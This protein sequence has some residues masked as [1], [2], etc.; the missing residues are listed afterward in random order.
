[1]HCLHPGSM[2]CSQVSFLG[3]LGLKTLWWPCMHPKCTPLKQRSFTFMLPN[4][5]GGHCF[6]QFIFGQVIGINLVA[7]LLVTYLTNWLVYG[8]SQSAFFGV[9]CECT[10]NGNV[11]LMA[12]VSESVSVQLQ[13][14]ARARVLSKNALFKSMSSTCHPSSERQ[15]LWILSSY[16]SESTS[17]ASLF[18]L[19]SPTVAVAVIFQ[20]PMYFDIDQPPLHWQYASIQQWEVHEIGLQVV[21]SR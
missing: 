6:R 16:N 21:W 13:V 8:D 12:T 10:F 4:C 2:Y 14:R 9:S 18:L 15:Q 1:M 5:T 17:W 7:S 3:R 11:S 20:L 19:T